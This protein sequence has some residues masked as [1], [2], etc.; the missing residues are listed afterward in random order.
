MTKTTAPQ[1]WL[2]SIPGSLLVAGL[3]IGGSL[4]L[5]LLS[6]EVI[7]KALATRLLGVMLGAMVLVYSNATS[8]FDPGDGTLL[9]AVNETSALMFVPV[10]NGAFGDYG[11][12]L[13]M[14]P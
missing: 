8:R 3:L 12:G 6:P 13:G 2:F 10:G 14:F 11:D 7:S 1:P 9:R 5:G 4:T